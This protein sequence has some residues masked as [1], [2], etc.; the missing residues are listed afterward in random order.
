M[1]NSA[2][3]AARV[4]AS[5]PAAGAPPPSRQKSRG[6]CSDRAP[7]YRCDD[8]ARGRAQDG[9][10]AVRRYQGLDW[11]WSR[12]SIPKRRARSSIPRCKLMID[13]VH[14]YDGY[15]VQ[16]TGDGI[17]ALFGAPVAHEDHPQRALYAA[18]GCRRSCGDTRA[19]LREPRAARRSRCASA[20]TPAKWW[21]ASIK[22]GDGAHR[23]HADRAYDQPRVADAGARADRLDRDQRSNTRKLGR[24]IFRAQAAGAD[25]G[26][27]RQR[28]GQRLR[29]DGLGPLRTRLQRSAGRG[30]TKF[31]GREREMDATERAARTGRA[32]HGQIVAAM[33]EAGV[34]KSRLFYEF[35][36]VASRDG[37]CWRRSRSRTARL[38][39]SAGDRS[40]HGLFR[41]R[42]R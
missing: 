9:H 39:V 8:A 24:G 2:P 6:A 14:R 29:G 40:A 36:A 3:N 23:V 20:S 26:K 41:D 34:G 28:T 27:G 1:R 22:T 38:G 18:L 11:N 35:K 4:S 10:R 13:A 21:S 31:V 15:I 42:V 19:K 7:R 16:S 25:P 12:T 17:F 37:W 33:A 30:L 5:W 32:G